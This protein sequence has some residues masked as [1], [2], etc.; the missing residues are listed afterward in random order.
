MVTIES[1]HGAGALPYFDALARLRIE[2]FREFPY[3][4]QGTLEY[5][6]R[7]L[8][9]YAQNASSVVV[10]ARDGDEVVGASTALPLL[11]H[12]ENVA[13]VFEQAGLDPRRVYY[14]GE[15]V[16]RATYRGRGI[17]HAFFDWREAAAREHGFASTA[18]CAVVRPDDHPSRPADYV[19]HDAFWTKR[20]YR[21][22]DDMI[23]TFAW[24]DLGEERET[25]KPMVFWLKEL[26]P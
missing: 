11:E 7:Y 8:T 4:Y 13:P 3:L 23:A 17:G 2:V 24:R 15:S 6:Q 10:I 26:A 19:P 16:L 1:A 18:F 9:S 22:R 25:D 21:K 14:F 20:G 12:S 5:E